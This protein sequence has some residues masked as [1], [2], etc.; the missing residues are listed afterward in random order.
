MRGKRL[1]HSLRL[2]TML[3]IKDRM[4]YFRDNDIFHSMGKY[5]AIMD[6]KVPLYSKLISFGD[7][8]KVAS[9]VTF[10]THDTTHF[11]LNRMDKLIATRGGQKFPE[12]VGCI[13]I[14]NNVFIGSGTFITYNV[15]IGS[16]V[17]IGACSLVNKD[18][19]DNCVVAGVPARIIETFEEYLKKRDINAVDG[20]GIGNEVVSPG[21]EEKLW[22]KFYRDREK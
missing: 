9:N 3:K 14:G 8:V 13:E 21:M 22:Q 1:W 2:F 15:K 12:K 4:Q 7:N 17:I 20:D 16:N 19:P 5:C 11:V 6:R 10:L 18:I